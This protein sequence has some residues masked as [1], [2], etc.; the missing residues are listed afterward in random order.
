VLL[1]L[2]LVQAMLL[3]L[4]LLLVLRQRTLALLQRLLPLT[5]LQQVRYS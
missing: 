1:V 2:S 5:T 3:L 4:L